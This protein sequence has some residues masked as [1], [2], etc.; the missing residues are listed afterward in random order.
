MLCAQPPQEA[1]ATRSH[2]N[3]GPGAVLA[4]EAGRG[5]AVIDPADALMTMASD[6][7]AEQRDEIAA[8]KRERDDWKAEAERLRKEYEPS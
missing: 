5:D 4:P 2:H 8:L 7:L 3:V 6:K 1:P